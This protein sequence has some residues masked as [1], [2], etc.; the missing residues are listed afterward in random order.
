MEVSRENVRSYSRLND[1]PNIFSEGMEGLEVGVNLVSQLY[2]N[3]W[4]QARFIYSI[5]PAAPQH[6]TH[7]LRKR[8][9]NVNKGE[10]TVYRIVSINYSTKAK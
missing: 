2:C 10:A 1:W 8:I 5:E 4:F 7:F 3:L 9:H 6:S